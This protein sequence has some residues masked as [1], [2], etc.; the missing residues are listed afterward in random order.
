MVRNPE[1]DKDYC[2]EYSRIDVKLPVKL[3]RELDDRRK[4][5]GYATMSELIRTL[6]RRYLHGEGK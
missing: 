3:F 4:A 2:D 5:E 1:S 6:V